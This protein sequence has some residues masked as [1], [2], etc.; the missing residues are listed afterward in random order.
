MDLEGFSGY[1]QWLW[2]TFFQFRVSVFGEADFFPT[3]DFIKCHKQ[4]VYNKNIP[5]LSCLCDTCENIVLLAKGM[6]NYKRLTASVRLPKTLHDIVETY[7]C[8]SDEKDCMFDDC[9]ECSSGKLCQL[10]D[11]N[12]DS[13]SDLDSNSADSDIRC[14]VSFYRWETPDSKLPKYASLSHLRKLSR[15]SKNL[16]RL[17][18]DKFIQK[19]PKTV[20]IIT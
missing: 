12:S 20:I 6:N 19:D 7:S 18:R 8:S 4:F 3:L 11:S 10:P 16:L 1:N 9:A 13:E 17:S 5:H 2:I 14:L 15:G